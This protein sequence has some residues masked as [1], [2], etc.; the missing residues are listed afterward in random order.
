MDRNRGGEPWHDNLVDCRWRSARTDAGLTTKL[1]DLRHYFAS[2]L[3]AA[4]CDVATVQRA[5][6]HS[7]ATTTLRTYAHLWPRA[8]DKTR[9]ASAATAAEVLATHVHRA[10][11]TQLR[12]CTT[13]ENRASAPSV[14]LRCR[15]GRPLRV[16]RCPVP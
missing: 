6:G 1:H 13:M 3:I 4:G 2:G 5:M 9:A 16:L 10:S 8:E 7:S 11:S 15:H 12:H 14:S